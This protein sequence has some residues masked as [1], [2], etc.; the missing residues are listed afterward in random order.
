[1]VRR[2]K[3]S[4]TSK[5]QRKEIFEYWNRRNKSKTYSKKL[6]ILFNECAEMILQYPT[7]G[8]DMPNIKCRKRLIRDFYFIYK[9]SNESVEIIS[10]WDTRQNPNKFQNFL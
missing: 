8:I 4:T 9:I 7:I 2:L 5:I 6:N 10:I 1:M 3:W